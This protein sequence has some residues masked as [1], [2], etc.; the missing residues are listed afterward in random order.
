M[1]CSATDLTRISPLGDEVAIFSAARHSGIPAI[2]TMLTPRTCGCGCAALSAFS[3]QRQKPP[4][5]LVAAET[6]CD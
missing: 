1:N 5:D 2:R 3:A 6:Y 4:K